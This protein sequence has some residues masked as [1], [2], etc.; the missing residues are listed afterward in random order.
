MDKTDLCVLLGISVFVS[1]FFY[2]T[3]SCRTNLDVL[4]TTMGSLGLFVVPVLL[5]L[6]F[7]NKEVIKNG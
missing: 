5:G 6:F 4:V 7:Y 3:C 1:F 2:F